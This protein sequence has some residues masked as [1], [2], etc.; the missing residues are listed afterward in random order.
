MHRPWLFK[1]LYLPSALFHLYSYHDGIPGLLKLSILE[2]L[3]LGLFHVATTY[4]ILALTHVEW[5]EQPR[6]YLPPR[7]RD[8]LLLFS[9][10]AGL[11]SFA[12]NTLFAQ[13]AFH[14]LVLISVSTSTSLTTS[15]R[16]PKTRNIRKTP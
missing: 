7:A 1:S 5:L 16:K 14:L 15:K 11:L 13:V 12:Q 3:V 6:H 4:V 2:G 8:Y 9:L 10:M